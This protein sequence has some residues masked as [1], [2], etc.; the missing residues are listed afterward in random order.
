MLGFPIVHDPLYN[1]R[2]AKPRLTLGDWEHHPEVVEALD[3]M[4]EQMAEDTMVKRPV[5]TL[6]GMDEHMIP[7]EVLLHESELATGQQVNNLQSKEGGWPSES[8]GGY[9]SAQESEPEEECDEKFSEIKEVARCS[10]IEEDDR[11]AAG[12]SQLANYKYCLQCQASHLL[13][14]M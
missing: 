10:E 11:F 9:Q 13:G 7:A 2:D 1:D 6:D 4:E 8:I 5:G 14:T 12:L 3:R